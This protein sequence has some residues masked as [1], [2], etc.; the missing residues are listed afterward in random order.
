MPSGR[1][2][3]DKRRAATQESEHR[4]VERARRRRWLAPLIATASIL[5]VAAVAVVAF[6]AARDGSEDIP[7]VT[8]KNTVEAGVL[9]KGSDGVVGTATAASAGLNVVVYLDAS[10]PACRAFEET[11]SS[12]LASLVASGDATLE[13]RPIAILDERFTGPVFST[14]ANNTLLC[15]ADS[16]PERF[17]DAVAAIFAAQPE[18]G[19]PGLSDD[20]LIQTMASA[21]ISEEDVAACIVDRRFADWITASTQRALSGPIDGAEIQSVRG[22][23]TVLVN[24]RQYTGSL[25]DTEA[26]RAFIGERG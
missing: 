26:F 16:S 4:R 18:E 3:R 7:A 25:T 19:T 6:N 20:E 15:V 13:Y 14:R 9:L 5:V 21:G 23:P 12:Y 11:N 10:C 8:P 2:T 1:S 17:L 24:G 22:T